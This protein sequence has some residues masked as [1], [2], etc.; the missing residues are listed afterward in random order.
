VRTNV[1][2][3]RVQHR[4]DTLLHERELISRNCSRASA[5]VPKDAPPADQ[6]VLRSRRISHPALRA[7]HLTAD[8]N[9]VAAAAMKGGAAD[10]DRRLQ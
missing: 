6:E 7:L 5:A 8:S 10:E 9:T 2:N 4:Y 1:P 3:A